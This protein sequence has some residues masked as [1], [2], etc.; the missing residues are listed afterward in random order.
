MFDDSDIGGGDIGAD[1]GGDISSD[2]GVES[3]DTGIDYID[4]PDSFDDVEDIAEDVP[5]DDVPEEI[6]EEAAE[7]EIPED[8]M[9]EPL[10][11]N[12][13]M[14]GETDE[15]FEDI[16]EDVPEDD[17][18]EEISE[19]TAEEEMPEEASD[20]PIDDSDSITDETGDSDELAQGIEESDVQTDAFT[21]LSN[22]MN[23]HNYGRDDFAEYSQDPEWRALHSKAFPDYN[24]PPLDNEQAHENTGNW[25]EIP[26]DIDYETNLL[27]SNPNYELGDEW[28][29]N[30]QR[31]VP[32]YEMRQRGFDV[33]A[34]PNLDDNDY[35]SYYPFDVWENPEV[36]SCNGD[37]M[38]DIQSTMSQWGNGSRAQIIVQWDGIPSG[39][40]FFAEQRD[41]KTY[42]CDPQTGETDVSYYFNNVQKGSTQFCQIDNLKASN[43][44]LDCCKGV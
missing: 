35:L 8:I 9:E 34:L 15:I 16:A 28:K 23:S 12:G 41:D 43:R 3:E 6:S 18:P 38:S 42:F 27:A 5:E 22:Y 4:V 29:V 33:T 19:E 1:V 32:T 14:A 39:H 11:D 40:T 36:N 21:E 13:E 10:E 30:C 26:N 20:E 37:G 17:V 25:K 31:C 2:I 7:K 24:L 44:I